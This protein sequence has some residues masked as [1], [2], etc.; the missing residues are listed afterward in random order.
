MR[1]FCCWRSQG[2]KLERWH[3]SIRFFLGNV[4]FIP[5]KYENKKSSANQKRKFEKKILGGGNSDIFGMFRSDP[6][7]KWSILTSIF[8]MGWFN[9]Q[10]EYS[11]QFCE[12]DLFGM[13]KRPPV[14]GDQRVTAWITWLISS[15]SFFK[16]CLTHLWGFETRLQ[17]TNRKDRHKFGGFNQSMKNLVKKTRCRWSKK[18]AYG[19]KQSE[20]C[21]NILKSDENHVFCV[22]KTGFSKPM[23]GHKVLG[24]WF[25]PVEWSSYTNVTWCL[26]YVGG[27]CVFFFFG[28]HS[29]WDCCIYL[30][31]PYKS[32]IHVGE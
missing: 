13:V 4:I 24:W 28:Y 30:H 6:W 15:R 10:L 26:W 9:H 14:R 5:K 12:R 21:K 11:W 3:Q 18:K 32:T 25:Q 31:L 16:I 8:Q 17:Q 22:K 2:W 7:K 20:I 1:G 19:L 23:P 29:G 27:V